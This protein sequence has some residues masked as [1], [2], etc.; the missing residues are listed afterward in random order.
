LE[1]RS[2]QARLQSTP[3]QLLQEHKIR[4][5]AAAQRGHPVLFELV[6]GSF[7]VEEIC[8]LPP[9][10]HAVIDIEAAIEHLPG[11]FFAR[12]EADRRIG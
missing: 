11:H 4:L 1:G 10:S 2:G 12:S 3:E 6:P 9:G 7:T 8:R 5:F